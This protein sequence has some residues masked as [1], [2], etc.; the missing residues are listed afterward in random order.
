M[1][2]ALGTRLLDNLAG[3]LRPDDPAIRALLADGSGG[4]AV[5]R[6]LARLALFIDYR[7]RTDDARDHRDD[8]LEALAGLF[9][10][11]RRRPNESDSVLLR[12]L[13]ALTERGGDRIWGTA[14]NLKSVFEAY[15]SGVRCY[16]AEGTGRESLLAD[17]DF[18]E[19]SDEWALSGGATISASARF[20]G[21]RGLLFAGS[22]QERCEQRLD[23]P[24][25]AGAYALCFFLKGK[26]AVEIESDGLRWD[27]CEQRHSGPRALQWTPE[28]TLNVRECPDEWGCARCLIL[29]PKDAPELSISF[30][31]VA[32]ERAMIDYARLFEK[33]PNPSYTLVFQY[34]GYAAG[35]TT[36]RLAEGRDDPIPGKEYEGRG[37]FD[38]SFIVGPQSVSGSRA[39]LD[40]LDVV[41]PRGIEVHSEFVGR[42]EGMEGEE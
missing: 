23:R 37:H 27:A 21:K 28:R 35:E 1:S 20:S 8:T 38:E 7:T 2:L 42:E 19:S 17:G 6:E 30:V 29:L 25:P 16:V 34:E 24:L 18:E 13:L 32:G 15:F 33:P 41:R 4:G 11:M 14:G 9:A 5:E 36:L 3:G 40:L 39:F 22:G 31:G 12:R 10:R 26:C